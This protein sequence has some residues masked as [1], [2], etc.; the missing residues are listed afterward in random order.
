MRCPHVLVTSE[1][2]QAINAALLAES[3]I[4][5]DP[6]GWQDQSHT[7]VAVYP[8]LCA[9][10]AHWRNES[11]KALAEKRTKTKK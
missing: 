9:E 11:H 1:H 10:I 2:V 4:L 8:L 7:F 5:Q 3:G 6:G